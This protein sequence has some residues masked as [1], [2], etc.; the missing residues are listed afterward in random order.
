MIASECPMLK[1]SKVKILGLFRCS[2][3][4]IL[5]SLWFH[6]GLRNDIPKIS[7]TNNYEDRKKVVAVGIPVVFA[8]GYLGAPVIVFV[9]VANFIATSIIDIVEKAVK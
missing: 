2:T 7:L 9:G 3:G 8:A 6:K 1:M 4:A 5:S